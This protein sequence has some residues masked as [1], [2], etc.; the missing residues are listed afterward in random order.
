MTDGSRILMRAAVGAA[1]GL[2]GTLALQALMGAGRRWAPET[3]PPMREEP[4]RFMIRK[5]EQAMPES[6]RAEIPEYVEDAAAAGLGLD[7]GV[8][9]GTLY[10]LL[11]PRG[12]N[13][14]VDGL[15]LGAACWATGYLGWLPALGLT[16][17]VWRQHTVQAVAP[18]MEHLVYGVVAVAAHDWLRRALRLERREIA[19]G[20]VA[21]M[22][23]AAL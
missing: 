12:G 2:A 5:M 23:S 1:G 18:A 13:P 20:R 10:G 21:S 17:P 6:A 4:G 7:Y 11:R 22:T 8:A 16:P 19:A 9:F 15:A 3:L 14:L